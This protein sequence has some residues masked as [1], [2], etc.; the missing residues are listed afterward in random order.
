MT[1]TS[2]PARSP[3]TRHLRRHQGSAGRPLGAPV[4]RQG[5]ARYG[6]ASVAFAAPAAVFIAL[7]LYAPLLYTTFISFTSYNGLG[8]PEWVGLANYGEMFSH[9]DFLR[10]VLN[11]L[12]WVFGTL[13]VPVGIGLAIA[14]TAWNLKGGSWLKTPFLIP[15]ALSGIG[16]GVI[17]TFVLTS[18]GAL[19][20]LLKVFGVA[21]TPRWLLDWPT[22]T[23][24]MI[25]AAS[26]QG[27]GV[28]AL[29]F[30]VGLQ[31]I[32][33]EP[34]EAARLDGASGLQLFRSVLWPM[35]RPLTAVV[36]GLSIVG[37]LKTFDIVWG[38]TKG[39]PGT[40]SQTLAL[41]MYKD[42]FVNSQ[43]GLG[44]AIAVFLTIVTLL[45]SVLYLRQQLKPDKEF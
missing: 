33:K 42:T 9:P 31:S 35:L 20:Q 2:A 26:W 23:I 43:Y 30:T 24:V 4:S 40:S 19:D 36:V 18:G 34:L 22:N 27:V 17:W 7:L 25:L 12:M 28:N 38:M 3:G 6:A 1:T 45:A 29:L 16:V 44:S 32:P 14:L 10:A 13:L 39:G 5:A 21:E 8:S 11:T 41:S 37:S 15:Y